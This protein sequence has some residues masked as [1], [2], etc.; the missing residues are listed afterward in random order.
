VLAANSS[1]FTEV[2]ITCNE[3]DPWS[4]GVSYFPEASSNYSINGTYLDMPCSNITVTKA[5]NCAPPL[6]PVDVLYCSLVCPLPSLTDSQYE[7]AKI[8]QGIVA[9]FSWV[10]SDWMVNCQSWLVL[11]KATTAFLL[12]SWLL[13]PEMRAFPKVLLIM[14]AAGANVLVHITFTR[15]LTK[16]GA[17][18][19]NKAGGMVLPTYAGHDEIWCGGNDVTVKPN[20]YVVGVGYSA[21]LLV[22]YSTDALTFFSS[23][24][25]L[26]GCKDS[27]ISHSRLNLPR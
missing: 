13:D 12:V 15:L 23:A 8:M 3:T 20:S 21:Q 26:Q 19:P 22:Q 4:Q 11:K 9:W 25:S 16:R 2:T 24:C 10:R 18:T 5:V 7:S 14:T 6:I 1:A 27:F 17:K